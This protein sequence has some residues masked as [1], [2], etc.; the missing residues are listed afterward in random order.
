MDMVAFEPFTIII[1]VGGLIGLLLILGAPIKPLRIIGN[2]VVRIMIG[3][4]ALFVI[5]SIG[6]IISFHIPI[7]FITASV[8]GLL[9][10]PGV[11]A[12]IAIEQF[13]L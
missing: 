4:L 5:N 8:S 13:V 1:I 10:I 11:I 7:N 2:G 12:L 6:T 3:A 9:G